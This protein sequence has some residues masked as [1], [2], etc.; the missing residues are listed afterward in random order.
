MSLI[1]YL[2]VFMETTPTKNYPTAIF[3]WSQLTVSR[4]KMS[5][6]KNCCNLKLK[7]NSRVNGQ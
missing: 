1:D 3:K 7:S 6:R 5:I 2:S 4:S